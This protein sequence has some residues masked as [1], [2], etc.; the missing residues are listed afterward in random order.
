MKKEI[1]MQD[2]LMFI[3]EKKD[4]R[5]KAK[6]KT[7]NQLQNEWAKK[8]GYRLADNKKQIVIDSK[9]AQSFR[10]KAKA[11]NLTQSEYLQKLLEWSNG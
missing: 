11:L 5:K 7:K 1:Q 2:G 8:T 3:R 9:V 4:L 6:K 10:D